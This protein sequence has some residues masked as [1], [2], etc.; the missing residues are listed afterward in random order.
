MSETARWCIVSDDSGHTYLCPAERR[1]E[2][3]E[4]LEAIEEYWNAHRYD[5]ECPADPDYLIRFD[6][7]LTFENPLIDGMELTCT[8][9]RSVVNV[10]IADY[11]ADVGHYIKIAQTGAIIRII[12]NDD[13][14][15]EM[16]GGVDLPDPNE[17]VS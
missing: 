1:D 9:G 2:A 10:D 17:V 11:R 16:S 12:E 13:V 4:T 3:E 5:D 14:V 7:G 15:V 6:S 8:V